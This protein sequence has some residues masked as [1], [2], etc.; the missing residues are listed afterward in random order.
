MRDPLYVAVEHEET[1]SENVNQRY[2]LLQERDK[3]IALSR[4]LE[5]E[6]QQ[7]TLIFARTKVGAAEL[8][9][10]LT[11][12]GYNAIAIHGDLS[13]A[14]RE[15]IL[16]RFRNGELRILV[17]TDV[18]A[19]GVDIPDVSHVINYD[20]PQLAI[21]YVHRIG[22]T[23]RAGRTGDAITFITPRQRR[24]L[25]VIEKHI[26]KPI[27]KGK[28][29]TRE[30][31]VQ[32]REEI[33]QTRLLDEIGAYTGDTDES[34]LDELLAQGYSP[35][36]V[37]AGLIRMFRAQQQQHPL[38]DIRAVSETPERERRENKSRRRSSHEKGMVRLCMN[39][40]RSSGLKPADV[41]YSIASKANIPGKVIGAIDIQPDE[42]YL[43]VPQDHVDVILNSLRHG[44]IRGREMRLARV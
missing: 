39:V 2:Y 1:T 16:R 37:A 17:A 3:I 24:L 35:E 5:V 8:A 12:R 41:V 21:E 42:T 22:R 33:F 27:S 10:T 26:G 19:R 14:E 13:Q 4:L 15:R 32:R 36:Q 25:K 43:D 34:L 20:I 38:E 29:P 23:A 44:K 7:S 18:M 40:G 6:D 31:V 28:L 9:E 30:T 11:E